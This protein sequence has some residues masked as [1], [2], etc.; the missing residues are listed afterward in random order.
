MAT[1]PPTDGRPAPGGCRTGFRQWF[2]SI[3]FWFDLRIQGIDIL[4]DPIGFILVVRGAASF[5]RF[6][7]RLE[8]IMALGLILATVSVLDV[9][10]PARQ[11]IVSTEVGWLASG[12]GIVMALL[13]SL[14]VWWMCQVVA[15][16]ARRVHAPETAHSAEQRR[17]LFLAWQAAVAVV[18]GVGLIASD[19]PAGVALTL[20]LFFAGVAV[21]GLLME[22][23]M[24]ARQLCR[25]E[26]PAYAP[27]LA[28]VK[29]DTAAAAPTS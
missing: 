1:E 24:Q 4:P 28:P 19:V 27:V 10:D 13:Q 18:L 9:Y 11:N 15:D 6:H 8:N 23:M 17:L 5:G 26:T 16:F 29:S 2:W 21:L 25:G 7:K 22:L 12:V 14:L 3:P 20:A